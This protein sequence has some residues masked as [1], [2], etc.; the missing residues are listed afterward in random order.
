MLNA[1][2]PYVL[3]V[4]FAVIALVIILDKKKVELEKGGPQ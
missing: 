3:I 2:F 4:I 1:M